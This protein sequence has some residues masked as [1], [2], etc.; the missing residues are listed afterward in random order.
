MATQL[1]FALENA[2]FQIRQVY[3]RS[4][5]SAEKLASDIHTDFTT[6]I[7]DIILDADLYII[8][9]TDDAVEL[10]ANG[11]N[12]NDKLVVH[13]SGSLPMDVIKNLSTNFGVFY[14]LQTFSKTRKVDFK[15]IPICI[16]ANSS[17]NENRLLDLGFSISEN[18]QRIKSE[19]RKILHLAAVFACNFPNFMYTIAAQILEKNKLDFKFLKPLIKETAAKVQTINPVDAQTGPAKRGDIKIMNQHLELL[20][21]SPEFKDIYK[22][23]SSEIQKNQ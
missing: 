23:I 7:K 5:E 1:A 10:L 9:V 2:G 22:L 18:V 8:S 13:T 21:D 12:F 20:T 14:P 19:K 3:S 11:L 16:E 17:D 6:N 15:S 4:V